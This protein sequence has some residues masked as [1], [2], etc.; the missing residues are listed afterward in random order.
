MEKLT[1]YKKYAEE[2]IREVHDRLSGDDSIIIQ[3]IEDEQRGHFLIFNNGWRDSQHRIYGCVAH[4]EVKSEGKIWLHQDKTD[5]VIGQMLLD[6]EIPASE[7]VLGLKH[8]DLYTQVKSRTRL[9]FN[10]DRIVGTTALRPPIPMAI[11]INE[12]GSRY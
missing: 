4:L 12:G 11:G 6:R 2:I 10:P 1:L 7:I 5:L 3:L 8:P 9:F